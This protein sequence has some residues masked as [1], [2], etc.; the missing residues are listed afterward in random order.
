MEDFGCLQDWDDAVALFYRYWSK[1]AM[2]VG[3]M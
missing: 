1:S 2:M 3:G